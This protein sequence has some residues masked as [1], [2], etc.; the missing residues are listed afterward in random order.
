MQVGL[1]A[2][3]LAMLIAVPLGL[4]AGYY[5]RLVDAVIARAT[6]VMLAFPFV[7][8][9][10]VLAAILGPSLLNGD[11]R[12]RDR[13]RCRGMIRIA[14]GETLALREADSCPAAVANGAGD[15]TIIFRHILP[16][17]T[18]TLIVQATLT[19]PAR[20][21]RRGRA[22]VPRARRPAAERVVGRDAAG[23]AVDYLTQAPLL[24]V[25]PGRRDR[26]RGA[27]V[28]PARRRRCATSSTR[29]DA[30]MAEPLLEVSDL[31]VRFDTDE[32]RCTRSTGSR[33]RSRRARC[34]GSSASRA[35]AR[36]STC[37]VARA[38][39]ARDGDDQRPRGASRASTC[40]RSR[41][42]SS[43]GC[44]AARS[45]SSSRSR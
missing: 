18:S 40:S 45:R 16:N 35:A 29:D 34:S 1:L 39:A 17:M 32:G 44:A 26:A 10:I 2:T 27:R 43:G 23:R 8:L 30:L 19:H 21:H 42:G 24:A 25:Y 28:Q 13:R 41:R 12:A 11:D 31:S 22:L 4:V 15:A 9:A 37:L 6:D 3:L 33:S 38:A 7:I 36:A 5:R 20:D 14:R